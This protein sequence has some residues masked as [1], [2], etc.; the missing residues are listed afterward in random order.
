MDPINIL[1]WAGLA[2]LVW[3]FFLA[4]WFK[5]NTLIADL[6]AKLEEASKSTKTEVIVK[7]AE[8]DTDNVTV[9]LVKKWAA[10]RKAVEDAGITEAVK[11]FDDSFKLLNA[12]GKK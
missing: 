7:Q 2:I 9:D 11:S 3:K 8:T 6:Q 1:L 5:G 4:D 10:A 12:E